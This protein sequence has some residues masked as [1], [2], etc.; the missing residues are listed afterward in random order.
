MAPT[1]TPVLQ[2]NPDHR[3]SSVYSQ[4]AQGEFVVQFSGVTGTGANAASVALP[5]WVTTDIISEITGSCY[6]NLTT[7]QPLNS[8]D[9][10]QTIVF[11]SAA[12]MNGTT[13]TIAIPANTRGPTTGQN[14]SLV[15]SAM[16]CL[17]YRA[18]TTYSVVDAVNT[19]ITTQNQAAW[20]YVDGVGFQLVFGSGWNHTDQFT[21]WY[22]VP[23]SSVLVTTSTVGGQLTLFAANRHNDGQSYSGTI[24]VRTTNRLPS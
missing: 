24:Y 17:G 18:G 2:S 5:S 8:P 14:G 10:V 6:Q 23:Q 16:G 12:N 19:T 9:Q 11:S 21:F 4:C 13:Q 7:S 22:T 1:M 15:N 3:T 20:Q